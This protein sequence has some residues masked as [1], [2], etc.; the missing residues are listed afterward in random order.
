MSNADITIYGYQLADLVDFASVCKAADIRPEE[1]KNF[2]EA[3]RK[4]YVEIEN[5][6]NREINATFRRTMDDMYR[7]IE[8]FPKDGLKKEAEK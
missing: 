8:T 7:N 6:I 3:I 5:R 2:N 1:I 4:A